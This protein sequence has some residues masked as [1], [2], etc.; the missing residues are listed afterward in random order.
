M[1][2]LPL[3]SLGLGFGYFVVPWGQFGLS[4]DPRTCQGKTVFLFWAL[5]AFG[6][7]AHDLLRA[8]ARYHLHYSILLDPCPQECQ[9]IYTTCIWRPLL[10]S[11]CRHEDCQLGSCPKARHYI[12]LIDLD[13]KS[14]YVDP[15]SARVA[16]VARAIY[17][18]LVSTMAIEF[19]PPPSSTCSPWPNP[20]SPLK[21]GAAGACS[22]F[23]P[24][25]QTVGRW[26]HRAVVHTKPAWEESRA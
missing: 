11:S 21:A 24:T 1:G 18:P 2:K 17:N 13:L 5:L 6:W 19:R 7:D 8:F 15:F 22:L 3:G 10:L 23:R 9:H 16:A 4:L 12:V 26:S 20:A 25:K 14:T